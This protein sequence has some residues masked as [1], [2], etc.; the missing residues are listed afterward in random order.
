MDADTGKTIVTNITGLKQDHGVALAHEFNRGFISDGGAG[1]VVIFDLKTLKTI[2]EAKTDKDADSI[3]YDPASKRVFRHEL[4][5]PNSSTVIDAKEWKCRFSTI[6]LGGGSFKFAVADG[7]G[8]VFV[9]LEDKN[10]V[11]A[12][13]SQKLDH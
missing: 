2:G 7:K 6:N 1:K 4:E 5:I 10:E 9:N 3:V 13:D 8:T 12:I 11:V